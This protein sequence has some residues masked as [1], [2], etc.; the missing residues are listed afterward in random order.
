[1]PV[2]QLSDVALHYEI[3]G[4][5]PPVILIAGMASDSASW[6]PLVAPLAARFT[7]IRPDNRAAGRTL[8][9]DAP[10]SVALWAADCAALIDHLGLGPAHV[11]GHSLGGMIG[12]QLAQDAPGQVATL[13][14]LAAAPLWLARNDLLFEV[15]LRLRAEGMPPDLWLRAFYPWLFRS[16]F[17][18][19]PGAV[20]GAVAMALAYPHAQTAGAMAHQAAALRLHDPAAVRVPAE[21]PVLALLAGD[22]LLIPQ[23]VAREALAQVPGAHVAVIEGAGHSLHWDAPE[24]VLH[25]WCGFVEARG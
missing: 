25:A 1:M 3:A 13:T 4:A 8:P 2:L 22:D 12:M 15:L 21:L 9:L 11:M 14:L 6:G 23:A 20:D 7:V 5:G 19:D 24:A 16:A 17:F 18:D 10:V